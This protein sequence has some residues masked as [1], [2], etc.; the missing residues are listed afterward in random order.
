MDLFSGA[1]E[2][3]AHPRQV[4][5]NTV[6][7]FTPGQLVGAPGSRS[8]PEVAG[9]VACDAPAE[10]PVYDS[11]EIAWVDA[12]MAALPT[13]QVWFT[14]QD[15][16]RSFGVSRATVARKVKAGLVPGIRFKNGRVVEEGAVRR[17]SRNQ[18]RFVLLA[19]RRRGSPQQG[20]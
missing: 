2:D 1:I 18:V 5:P 16:R 9:V 15:I 12:C 4:S 13:A 19:V 20:A 8:G 14:Y 3:V 6:R 10:A 7:D 11:D 17:F